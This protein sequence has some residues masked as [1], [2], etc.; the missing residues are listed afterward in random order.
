MNAALLEA[1]RYFTRETEIMDAL[2]VVCGCGRR[3][4]KAWDGR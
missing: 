2:H 4:E 3:T 1:V